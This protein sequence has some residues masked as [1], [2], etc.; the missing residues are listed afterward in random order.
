MMNPIAATPCWRQGI[1]TT[2]QQAVHDTQERLSVW[3][4]R[5]QRSLKQF[6]HILLQATHS[7]KALFLCK[8]HSAHP[9]RMS[10]IQAQ[11]SM[12]SRDFAQFLPGAKNAATQILLEPWRQLITDKSTAELLRTKRQLEADLGAGTVQSVRDLF[13]KVDPTED[14]TFRS[15][16]NPQNGELNRIV[17]FL[18][19]EELLFS[20][21]K[22]LF[23]W[24]EE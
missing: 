21:H 19:L 4:G 14:E 2:L 17:Y 7:F 24:D 16:L 10:A 18:V 11:E 15:W 5:V 6:G 3:L 13:N 22:F 8:T 12:I 1:S 9:L 20:R 23:G